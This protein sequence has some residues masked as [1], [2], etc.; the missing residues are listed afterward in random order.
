MTQILVNPVPADPSSPRRTPDPVEWQ[1]FALR[2]FVENGLLYEVN[3]KVLWD[4]GI[5][6]AVTKEGEAYTG[7][8]VLTTNPPSR[9][10]DPDP[11][12][13]RWRRLQRWLQER[14]GQVTP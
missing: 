9:I 7:L 8:R 13:S 14:L 11:G 5:A 3:R 10:L 12:D 6:L 4:L 1:D 2:D